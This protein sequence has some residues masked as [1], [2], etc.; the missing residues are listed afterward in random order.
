MKKNV[1]FNK[2][3]NIFIINIEKNEFFFYKY[4]KY[5]KINLNEA[6]LYPC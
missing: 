3:R 2:I 1:Y 5:N 6:P 4:S